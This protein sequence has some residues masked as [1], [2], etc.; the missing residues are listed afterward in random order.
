MKPTLV[1]VD[2]SAKSTDP[3]GFEM[4]RIQTQRMVKEG[5]DWMRNAESTAL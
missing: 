4:K 3:F 2:V 5:P 1:R